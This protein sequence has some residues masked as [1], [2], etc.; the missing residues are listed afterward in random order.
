M[1]Q[2]FKQ[3]ALFTCIAIITGLL[4]LNCVK[5]YA[6]NEAKLADTIQHKLSLYQQKNPASLLFVHF[7]K[8]LYSNNENVWFTAYLLNCNKP[9]LHHTLSV[10]LVNDIDHTV[11]MEEKFM[12]R[13]GIGFGNLYLTDSV[14]PG[15]YTFM[16]YTN[17]MVNHKPEALFIQPITIKTTAAPDFKAILSL[18]DTTKSTVEKA[19]EL[20]LNVNGNDYLPVANA[21]VSYVLIGNDTLTTQGK[22]KTNKAGQYTL[23]VPAG[24]NVVKVQV[25]NKQSSQF[26]HL[27]MPR[28][29][30]QLHVKFYPEGGSLVN[31]LISQVGWEVKNSAGQPVRATG[32]M[33]CNDKA[34]DT[35]QTDSYGMGRFVLRPVTGV[36]Y[37]VKL[38]NYPDVRDT[39]YH[40]P[41]A[42]PHGLVMGMYKA[43]VDDTL[44]LQL[45]SSYNGTVY[46]HIHNYQQQFSS[47]AVQVS[48]TFPR[49][50]RVA[51][52]QIPKGLSEI[53]LTDSLGKPYAERMFFA[54]Y[55]QRDLFAAKTN[56][57]IYNT[58]EK[59][60]LKLRMG[61]QNG[62]PIAG[63][64]SVACVQDN[65]LELKKVNDIESYLYL[66]SAIGD[67][68]L[69]ERY[70]G[71]TA[72]DKEYLERIILI[73]GWRRYSWPDLIRINAADT[74]AQQTSLAFTGKVNMLGKSIKKPMNFMLFRDSSS[75]ILST[76]A[77]G[78][79]S[80]NND[81]LINPQDKPIRFLINAKDGYQLQINNPYTKL[82]HDLAQSLNRIDYENQSTLQ[83]SDNSVIK[84]LEKAIQL[85]VVKVSALK[86]GSL[87]GANKRE[88]F[89]S[90][91]DY[92][93]RNNIFNCANH[94]NEPDNT[95]PIPGNTYNG[96]IYLGCGGTLP[97]PETNVKT[98]AGI[99]ES[100]QFYGSDYGIVNPSQPEY[101]STIF[102]RHL[103]P[104]TSLK[105]VDLS[106]Y[107]GDIT[108][109]F[110]IVVQGITTNG[111]VFNENSITIIKP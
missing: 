71:N 13:D 107:T 19:R 80:L 31:N 38:I 1:L 73:K 46:L 15:N 27:V 95:A 96:K 53:T 6:Q 75:T 51:L 16:V 52:G 7:D 60:Q 91:F 93:C 92:V 110:R 8:T 55:N 9:Q 21:A 106:F 37:K 45:K 61:T 17:R 111:V 81:N 56:K 62:L 33:Y 98:L 26:L 2:G 41:A 63:F 74:I 20:V 47:V 22:G 76:T 108:G 30:E 40:L 24:K 12:M 104:V 48:A 5:A 36:A 59:V 72:D 82:N 58:R 11:A 78:D 64:V 105:D 65:R 109:K 39:V 79:F 77:T 101:L 14:P 97:P 68:P 100:K 29:K 43:I 49:K 50:V 85:K 67:L 70:L 42:L 66:K 86:D 18:K 10:S 99:Y 28:S 23:K 83:T 3:I 90:C 84:G 44:N 4:C 87:Y 57:D 25:K 103:V 34:A 88:T 89:N 94:R 54:H 32:V 102:W 35:I 69:K